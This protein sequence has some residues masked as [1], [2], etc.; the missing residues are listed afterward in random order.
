MGSSPRIPGVP[1]MRR[2]DL[3]S[4]ILGADSVPRPPEVQPHLA[5]VGGQW[6]LEGETSPG[7]YHPDQ[8]MAMFTAPV[9]GYNTPD[10]V[11]V[12]GDLP[13]GVVIAGGVPQVA[14]TNAV[15]GGC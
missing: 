9:I 4:W 14:D 15:P 13:P 2:M 7:V 1:D 5:Q 3:I 6:W 11:R 8:T 10:I 12:Y